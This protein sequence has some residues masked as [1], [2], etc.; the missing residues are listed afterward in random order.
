MKLVGDLASHFKATQLNDFIYIFSQNID[1]GP[2]VAKPPKQFAPISPRGGNV[3]VTIQGLK[4]G[5]LIEVIDEARILKSEAGQFTDHFGPL[6]EHIY[7]IR[8]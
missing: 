3:T 6:S 7:K 8:M 5:T 2:N 4:A 1:L